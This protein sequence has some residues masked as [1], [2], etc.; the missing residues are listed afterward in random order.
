MSTCDKH[1]H[2]AVTASKLQFL[3]EKNN[4]L[5]LLK[6]ARVYERRNIQPLAAVMVINQPLSAA[7]MRLHPLSLIN[8]IFTVYSACL[9]QPLYKTSLI[10]LWVWNLSLHTPH[11]SSPNHHLPFATH[12][13]TISTNTHTHIQTDI[14]SNSPHLSVVLAMWPKSNNVYMMLEV[15]S[16]DGSVYAVTSEI[17][18]DKWRQTTQ[19][20]DV[21]NAV[22][23]EVQHSQI[24][25][26]WQTFHHLDLPTTTNIHTGVTHLPPPGSTNHNQLT[27][28]QHDPSIHYW[29]ARW[30]K[31]DPTIHVKHT[32]H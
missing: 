31:M 15:W 16:T 13:H 25:Q 24:T 10:Y 21:F 30:K 22:A 29:W 11:I 27:L 14:Y 20:L 19:V 3:Q 9:T 8:S 28:L 32:S 7:S 26:V 23:G 12:A 4:T 5:R 2:S 1:N 18:L 17:E 6:Q